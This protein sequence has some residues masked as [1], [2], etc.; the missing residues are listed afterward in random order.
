MDIYL[1]NLQVEEGLFYI[2]DRHI[3][4]QISEDKMLEYNKQLNEKITEKYYAKSIEM[5]VKKIEENDFKAENL[6]R[7]Y[8]IYTEDHIKFDKQ[9]IIN[10]IDENKTK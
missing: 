3:P 10:N 5:I 7:L 2:L 1:E 4:Y 9:K 8:T 6:D